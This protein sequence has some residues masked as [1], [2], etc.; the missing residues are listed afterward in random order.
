MSLP[1]VDQKKIVDYLVLRMPQDPIIEVNSNYPT[2][3]AQASYGVYVTNV[4]TRAREVNQ[5]GVKYG[6]S[7]YTCSDEF[8]ILYVSYHQDPQSQQVEDVIAE[9]AR[10][11]NFFDGYFQVTYQRVTVFGQRSEKYTYTFDI[12]RL[13]FN[14]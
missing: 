11:T 14:N 9:L 12:K 5:L 4:Y 6:A 3:D 10:D 2:S 1:L 8:K 13:E 7:M